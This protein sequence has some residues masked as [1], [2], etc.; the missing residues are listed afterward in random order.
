LGGFQLLTPLVAER[1]QHSDHVFRLRLGL[2]GEWWLERR[3]LV[4]VDASENCLASLDVQCRVVV[5]GWEAQD[6]VVGHELRWV[7]AVTAAC[8][9]ALLLRSVPVGCEDCLDLLVGRR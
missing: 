5:H 3:Y 4:G 7:A 2:G 9:V 1:D 6:G 8:E